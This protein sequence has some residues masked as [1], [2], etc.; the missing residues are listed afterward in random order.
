[1]IRLTG[2]NKLQVVLGGAATASRVTVSYMDFTASVTSGGTFLTVTD[3]AT[4]V[5]I[6]DAPAASTTRQVDHISL[7]ALAAMTATFSVWDGT[8]RSLFIVTLSS[9]DTFDWSHAGGPRVIDNNGSIR[10]TFSNITGNLAVGGTLAVTGATTLSAA[11]TYG[12][13]TLTNAVTGTGK[14]VLDTNAVHVTP[15]LGTPSAVVLT[16]ATGLPMTTGV[17][18]ILP[19]ANGGTGIAYFTAAGPTVARVYTFPDAAATI[20]RTDAGQTFTGVQAMTSPAITTSITTPSTSFT[21]LAGAT[22]SLTIGGTGATAVVAIPGTLDATNSTT[23]GVTIAGGLAVAK[24]VYIGT[25]LNVGGATTL[26]GAL[27]YGGVTLSNA[28]TGT[29]NMVLSANQTLTGTLTA[30]IANFS[31]LLTANAGVA[32]TGALSATTYHWVGAVSG[33]STT[34]G[35][36]TT[37]RSAT[38]GILFFGDGGTTRYL[39]HDAT[40]F[41]LIGGGVLADSLAGTGSRT[42]LADANG[43]LSAPVSDEEWKQNMRDIPYGIETVMALRPKIWDYKDHKRFG[44]QDYIG[45]GARETAKILPEVTGQDVNGAYYLTDEKITAVLVKAVQQ[46]NQ[47][48]EHVEKSISRFMLLIH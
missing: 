11:L 22:T 20:A 3:G 28:V 18:G 37:R 41:N 30:A 35:D 10:Q 13:V 45:F 21:A 47:R 38:T 36:I 1:M 33:G 7:A 29:G 23:G 25:D 44:R 46:V 39:Y 5:D 6:C 4:P 26:T 31:G 34:A 48:L 32:V 16:N 17:T 24:K 12:G 19:T 8:A 43:L 9:G 40:N 15:N 27:T 2:T 14:M 42:V